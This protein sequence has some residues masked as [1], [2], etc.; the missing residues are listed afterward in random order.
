MAIIIS[1]SPRQKKA[2]V[3]LSKIGHAIQNFSEKTCIASIKFLKYNLVEKGCQAEMSKNDV[4]L[5]DDWV[6][7]IKGQILKHLVDIIPDTWRKK[8]TVQTE[9]KGAEEVEKTKQNID[10]LGQAIKQLPEP[11]VTLWS[12]MKG[13]F[14][15]LY[16]G[17]KNFAGGLKEVTGYLVTSGGGSLILIE[18]FK[19][20]ENLSVEK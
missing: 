1:Q 2:V 11:P 13:V 8:L 15:S 9:V 5:N 17:I 12:K 19:F 18:G 3:V 16:S 7:K 6:Q 20:L 10:S 14:S 4:K